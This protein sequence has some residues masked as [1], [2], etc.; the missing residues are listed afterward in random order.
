[1]YV[2]DARRV[3]QISTRHRASTARSFPSRSSARIQAIRVS[4]EPPTP[5]PRP[6]S[7]GSGRHHPA[8][9]SITKTRRARIQADISS[10][11]ERALIQGIWPAFWRALDHADPSALIQ[12]FQVSTRQAAPSIKQSGLRLMPPGH[13]RA[14][15]Q[16]VQ[17]EPHQ[18]PHSSHSGLRSPSAAPSFKQSRLRKIPQALPREAAFFFTI[19]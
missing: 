7:S 19:A 1:M 6:H 3:A 13:S 15:I 14:H 16:A 12:G 8:A 5:L 4:D 9:P 2:V 10:R 11:P 17:V 18:R